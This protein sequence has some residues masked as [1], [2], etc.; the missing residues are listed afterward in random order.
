M[1]RAPLVPPRGVVGVEPR[2]H[3]RVG[4]PREDYG[5]A[6][7]VVANDPG[8]DALIVIYI[9]PLEAAAAEVARQLVRAIA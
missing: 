3:D 2:R 5:R 7:R 9:P 8:I 1:T 6:I 4:R